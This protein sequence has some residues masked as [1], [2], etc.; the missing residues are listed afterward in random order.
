MGLSSKGYYTLKDI[1]KENAQIMWILS[2]R[3]D[4]K[5]YAVKEF[6][7][8][9]AIKEKQ[10]TLGII[11][12]NEV[13][14]KPSKINKY[15]IERDEKANLIKK[16]TNNKWTHTYCRNGYIYL[17]R[18]DERGKEEKSN[19]PIGEYFALSTATHEKSTGHKCKDIICE[20]MLT[21]GIYLD[22]E[23]DKLM[24]LISTITRSDDSN[25]KIFLLGN[26]INRICP[27]FKE[28]GITNIFKQEQG[29]I[30]TYYYTQSDG[31][32]IKICCERVKSR[33]VKSKLFLGKAEKSIQGGEWQVQ[34]YPKLYKKLE[35]FEEIDSITYVSSNNTKFTI[36]L[37]ID[38]NG[39]KF[40]FVHPA[41]HIS[42]R[43][44]TTDF[45]T[46]PLHT[47]RLS[48]NKSID[49]SIHNCFYNNKVMYSD[50]LTA[51]DF[52]N[53]IKA[54]KINPLN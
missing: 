7:L 3:G 28:W 23:P 30:D 1:L 49:I 39:N 40:C 27:Y 38:E 35:E 21:D 33:D 44:L 15:F 25:I 45:S 17:A 11:R 9:R 41:K 43:V 46:N 37:L 26:T 13:D 51:T 5:S 10:P 29:T 4:G 24:Q 47:P 8:K 12:R 20:E 22:D 32:K 18:F 50:N 14:I 42:E 52:W 54:E 31:N 16:I 53:S 6:A 2:E 36:R 19:Y 48:K 34:E